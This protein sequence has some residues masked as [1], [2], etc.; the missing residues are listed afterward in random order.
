MGN[1]W[2]Y[3]PF[4]EAVEVNPSVPLK[5]GKI[6]P[7]VD[8]KAVESS[9]RGAS[10]SESREFKSGGARFMPFDTL[11]ARITPCL[12]N[13]K[14]A[15]YIP[16][17]GVGGPAFGST[18]FIVI[19]GREGVTDNDYA[20]YLTKWEEFRQFAIS[21]MTGSSG[22]QRVPADSLAKF[23]AP[24]PE[25]LSEQRAIAHIL[26]SLDDKIELNR[27]MAQT[28]ESI[29]RAIF[30][31][32]FVDFDPVKAKME[33]KQPE[34]MTE[35]IA[36][37]FPD[38]LVDSELGMIPEG[39]ASGKFSDISENIRINIRKDAINPN[40]CYIGLE[41]IPRKSLF[42]NN[43]G[44]GAD[45]TS[46]KHRFLRYDLLFGKLRPYFHKIIIAPFNGIC[47][48][49]I[50]VIRSLEP[51]W[52]SLMTLG[53][54]QESVVDN[55]TNQSEGTRMPRTNWN[56][57]GSQPIVIPSKKVAIAFDALILPMLQRV[58]EMAHENRHLSE[59]RDTQLPRLI[60]GKI[61]VNQPED[62]A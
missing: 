56:Q 2:N 4:T 28:L 16:S 41:H 20:Y 49:D 11:M 9:R 23:L 26:G 39:W 44:I 29:A 27:Q 48:T 40:D 12:E 19:R 61:R 7:F 35:E 24:A 1:K 30:K 33:G 54:S 31:S 6:Y 52:Y 14:I 62:A 22:R 59:L 18:E 47:S 53:L 15:R 60:S 46:N 17:E 43:W 42:L 58:V 37:L 57:V 8:M 55:V 10:E 3:L 36:A 32:W 13:G 34:G 5:R 50:L 51:H 38:R 21:Q 45:V 25:S